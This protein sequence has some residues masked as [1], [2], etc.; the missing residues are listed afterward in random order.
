MDDCSPI[1]EKLLIINKL[2][3]NSGDYAKW[4]LVIRCKHKGLIET[5]NANNMFF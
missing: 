3:R 1:L 5:K 4:K 2:G